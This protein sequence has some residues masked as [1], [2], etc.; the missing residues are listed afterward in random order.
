MTWYW[1][2]YAVRSSN[3]RVKCFTDMPWESTCNQLVQKKK[4]TEKNVLLS[5]GNATPGHDGHD[6]HGHDGSFWGPVVGGDM[7]SPQ[8]PVLLGPEQKN[9]QYAWTSSYLPVVVLLP[10]MPAIFGG[11]R[12]FH[13]T[14]IVAS[15]YYVL[16][17]IGELRMALV[18]M[19]G[20]HAR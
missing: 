1:P 6:G 4:K 15:R 12:V 18:G 14:I 3:L 5:Y 11:G 8:A 10:P 2:S 19:H 13:F 7:S 20:S 17:Y 9:W 16:L